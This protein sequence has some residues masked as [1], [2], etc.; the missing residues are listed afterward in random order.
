MRARVLWMLPLICA[1][2]FLG[3]CGDDS[4]TSAKDDESSSSIAK[5]SSSS[6]KSSS[7]VA[8]SSSKVEQLV[9]Y[10]TECPAGKTCTYAPTEQLNPDITYGEFLDTRDYQ[11]Y[12][13]VTIGDQTWMA[14]NLNYAYTGVPYSSDGYTSDSTSWCYNNVADSCA[15]YGRLYTWA[16]AI[17]SVALAK[18]GYTCGFGI[19]CNRLSSTALAAN[20]IQGVCPSGWHLPRY[21][22]WNTLFTAVG[23][24]STVGTKLKST[25]GWHSDGNGTDA[26]GFS[27]FPAGYRNYDGGFYS[28][29]SL[30]RFW[31]ASQ[32]ENYSYYAYSMF[33]YYNSENAYL[34]YYKY[35]GYS[36]RCLRD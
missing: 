2:L 34:Y 28:A 23:G 4:G 24:A 11:V 27:V 17:D 18:D 14:Q 21:A 33:L 9:P 19:T 16:A 8:S 3:G 1:P 10:T 22:E 36:V 6:V 25:S 35:Y 32:G 12:K 7:S 5:E 13:T 29:G 26:Y 31:S 30:A 15:K 20:P